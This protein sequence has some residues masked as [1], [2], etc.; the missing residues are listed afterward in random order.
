MISVK[1]T[2]FLMCILAC[3]KFFFS[4]TLCAVRIANRVSDIII[5]QVFKCE[6]LPFC[7]LIVS[8]SIVPS[9]LFYFEKMS[10]PVSSLYTTFLLSSI[11]CI[12]VAM[13]TKLLVAKP[14]VHILIPTQSQSVFCESS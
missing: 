4:R 6:K 13:I 7:F 5:P 12:Q 14:R 10:F 1:N 11:R 2:M 9:R 3:F 8:Y